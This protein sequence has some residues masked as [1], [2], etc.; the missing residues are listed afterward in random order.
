MKKLL[1]TLPC[2]NEEVVLEQTLATVKRYAEEHFTNR[3]DWQ[4]LILDNASV[5]QTRVIAERWRVNFPQLVITDQVTTPGRGVALR[6]SWLRHPG[7]DIYSYMDAD[8]ATDLKDFGTLINK[9]DQGYDLVTGSRYL[10]AAE[11]RRTWQRLFLSRVYNRL[12][13]MVLR[14]NFSDAQCGFKA[15][16]RRLVTELIP[17]TSDNGWFWDTELMILACRRGYQV[18]EIP[19]SWREVRD[20]LR[21]SKVSPWTEVRRQLKNIY[22]MRRRLQR[23]KYGSRI[24]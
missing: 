7:Y 11:V 13:Q 19:V 1:I 15:F 4:I 18:L 17:L 12:L 14:V 21:S 20:E 23:E 22:L 3:Y 2:Y 16:S 10:A 9:V 6:E 5:D 8:L 24:I